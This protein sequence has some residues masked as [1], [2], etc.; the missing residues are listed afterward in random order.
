MG[1]GFR[2]GAWL[3]WTDGTMERMN[4]GDGGLVDAGWMDLCLVC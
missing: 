4:K 3:V 2:R 1:G